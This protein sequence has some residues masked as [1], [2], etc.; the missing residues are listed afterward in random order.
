MK[1]LFL[2]RH[3][4][5]SW[6]DPGLHDLDR[7][8]NGR[9]RRQLDI[10][11]ELIHANGAF[12][13]PVFCST[14]L[15]ARLTLAGLLGDRSPDVAHFD[16]ALYTFDDDELLDWLDDRE[17]NQLTLIGHNPALEDLADRLLKP[18]PGHLPTCA[19]VGMAMPVTSWKNIEQA[20][21]R[22]LVFATPKRVAADAGL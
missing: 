6:K 19:F 12:D 7:P 2:I 21:A 13:G 4:K 17:E 16:E 8:L 18:G 9:G 10:M 5:S 20:K 11:R 22:L 3:A 15:R 14:A 1:K